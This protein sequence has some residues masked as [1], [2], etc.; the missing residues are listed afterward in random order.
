M[1]DGQKSSSPIT[2]ISQLNL[3][4]AFHLLERQVAGYNDYLNA[5][6]EHFLD[7]LANFEALVERI[8]R[9]SI[10]SSNEELKDIQT[11]NLKM[12]MVPCME[13]DVLFRLMDDRSAR[14]KK[15]H[16][17]Y[18]EYLKLMK[19]YG[20]LEPQQEKKYKDYIKKHQ[21]RIKGQNANEGEDEPKH[22][23]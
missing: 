12:L 19:H 18:I 10:F 9:E 7:T 11:E 23:A 22:P 4:D 5:D 15:A 13:A 6:E 21:Q 3:L 2:D 20:L 17:Y 1:V 16:V 14:V 8:Q